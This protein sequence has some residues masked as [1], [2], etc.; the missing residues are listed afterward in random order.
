MS[1]EDVVT[2]LLLVQNCTR[3]AAVIQNLQKTN[4]ESS[5]HGTGVT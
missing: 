5:L 2:E 1:P 4:A 3:K